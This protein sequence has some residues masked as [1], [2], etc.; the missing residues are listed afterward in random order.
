MKLE[1]LQELSEITSINSRVLAGDGLSIYNVAEGKSWAAFRNTIY[2]L[3]SFKNFPNQHA[4]AL[5]GRGKVV[6]LAAGGDYKGA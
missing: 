1:L 4:L 5:Q 6:Y 3:L 2:S